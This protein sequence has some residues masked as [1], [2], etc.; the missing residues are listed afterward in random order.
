MNSKE[1]YNL[2]REWKRKQS[3]A[4]SAGEP[5]RP[6]MPGYLAIRWCGQLNPTVRLVATELYSYTYYNNGA[7]R[8]G[9]KTTAHIVRALDLSRS[10]AKRA[11]GELASKG[12]L[13]REGY[14][15][16]LTEEFIRSV[17][18]ERR[19]RGE[20]DGGSNWAM[21][22]NEPRVKMSH[23]SNWAMAQIEPPVAQI[24]PP[25]AH[26]RTTGGSRAAHIKDSV[27]SEDSKDSY[28][29]RPDTREESLEGERERLESS[30]RAQ[31]E[32]ERR[33]REQ[34]NAEVRAILNTY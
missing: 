32:E 5:F 34:Y 4:A 12:L 25:V 19:A 26:E 2:L 33:R 24:E 29:R 9:D 11:L 6:V 14:R 3:E 30:R 27:N 17:M 13:D 16:I 18:E 20:G 22:Q 1:P 31:A 23:G 10:T 21:A 7:L 28:P 8:S 15:F